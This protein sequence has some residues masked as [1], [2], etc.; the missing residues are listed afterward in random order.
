MLQVVRYSPGDISAA[1]LLPLLPAEDVVAKQS[2]TDG[3]SYDLS[4]TQMVSGDEVPLLRRL[5]VDM[6]MKSRVTGRLANQLLSDVVVVL[7][8]L[9]LASCLRTSSEPLTVGS[10]CCCIDAEVMFALSGGLLAP[11]PLSGSYQ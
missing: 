9:V 7:L 10:L 2:S 11:P 6:Q 4:G 1:W 3:I 5:L 8:P